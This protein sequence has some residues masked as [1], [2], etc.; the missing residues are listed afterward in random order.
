MSPHECPT[1]GDPLAYTF[2]DTAGLGGWKTGDGYNTTPDTTHYVCFACASAWKQ[3]LSG[4]LTPDM[5]GDIAF[6]T[7]RDVECGSR[8]T[9]TRESFEVT[10]VE[11]TCSKGHR[12][13][14]RRADAGEL[15]LV[16]M[17]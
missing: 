2:T 3:R 5:I 17:A 14:V 11:L 16:A 4:P 8:L 10:E 7:C 12:Y 13:G 9:V 1:C 6:F 15:T